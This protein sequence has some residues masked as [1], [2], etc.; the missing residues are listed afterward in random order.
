MA[1][2]GTPFQRAGAIQGHQLP[3]LH[4]KSAK[5]AEEQGGGVTAKARQAGVVRSR[6]AP[7]ERTHGL[8]VLSV[9]GA[10]GMQ[11][12]LADVVQNRK[13]PFAYLT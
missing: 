3:G 11:D 2:I 7:V 1:G 13:L 10:P 4:H 8:T 6:G 12:S 5:Y 9:P